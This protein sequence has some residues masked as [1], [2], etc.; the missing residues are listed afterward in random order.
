MTNSFATAPDRGIG[1]GVRHGVIEFVTAPL[2]LQGHLEGIQPGQPR[3]AGPELGAFRRHVIG[4]EAERRN[5][6][7]HDVGDHAL[8]GLLVVQARIARELGEQLAHLRI[9]L[10]LGDGQQCSAMSRDGIDGDVL[11]HDGR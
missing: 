5:L 3:I 2:A 4:P 8:F 10:R 6:R 7:G 9:S 11:G 1:I